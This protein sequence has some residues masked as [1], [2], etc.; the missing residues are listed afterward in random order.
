MSTYVLGT[1]LS[2][3]GSACLLKDGEI[4]VA[5]EKERITRRKHDGYNDTD[6]IAYCLRAAGITLRDVALVVQN[7]PNSDLRDCRTHHAGVR[8]FADHPELPIVT[9]S[10]HLAHAYSTIGTCPFDEFSVLIIDGM[11]NS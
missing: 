7:S 9:I 8:P 10:H 2:H 11:G 4:C 6:A 5:I 3:N 1:G